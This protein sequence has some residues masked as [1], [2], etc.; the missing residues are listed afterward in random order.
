MAGSRVL[1]RRSFLYRS[2]G[3]PLVIFADQK[4]SYIDAL[5]AADAGEY[6]PLVNFVADCAIDVIRMVAAEMRRTP[7]LPAEERRAELQATLL[8]PV[9]CRMTRSTPSRVGFFDESI[10]PPKKTI[11]A[12]PLSQPLTVEVADHRQFDSWWSSGRL[13]FA[14]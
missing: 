13:P 3:V 12:R 11:G 1:W 8:G 2:P 5:E 7:R 10:C 4:A 14:P 6:R 9:V